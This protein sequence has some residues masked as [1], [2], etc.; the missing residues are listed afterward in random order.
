M[1]R[2]TPW[3]PGLSEGE[4][5]CPAVTDRPFLPTVDSG[6]QRAAGRQLLLLPRAR[7][8]AAGREAALCATGG[9]PSHVGGVW[10]SGLAQ[11]GHLETLQVPCSF[12]APSCRCS[13]WCLLPACGRPWGQRRESVAVL[14]SGDVERAGAGEGRMQSILWR[15]LLSTQPT[16][17]HASPGTQVQKISFQC[18][19]YL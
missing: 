4:P 14:R 5:A 1:D 2:A 18:N 12:T 3:G 9:V 13:F 8:P 19:H 11:G 15:V 16:T 6:L 17:R 10:V 7:A